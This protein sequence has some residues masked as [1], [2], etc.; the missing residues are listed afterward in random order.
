MLRTLMNIL[1]TYDVSTPTPAGRRRLRHVAWTCLDF[2][3]RVQASVFEYQVGEN[4]LVRLRARLLEEI[5]LKED[6]LRLY[7]LT[8]NFEEVVESHGIDQRIDF[9]GPLIV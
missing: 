3:Q 1:V 4:E 2:G 7:R 5:D 8:D 9:D 6:S